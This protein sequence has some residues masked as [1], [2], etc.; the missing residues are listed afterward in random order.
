[1]FIVILCLL[2]IYTIL[3]IIILLLLPFFKNNKPH[4]R[5][6]TTSLLHVTPVYPWYTVTH[7]LE[8]LIDLFSPSVT[9]CSFFCRFRFDFTPYCHL[10]CQWF[11]MFLWP[12]PGMKSLWRLSLAH[13]WPIK[14]ESDI[15][16]TYFACF[17]LTTA[18]MSDWCNVHI[19]LS[20]KPSVL[21]A[22]DG[23]FPLLSLFRFTFHMCAVI[24]ELAWVVRDWAK[25]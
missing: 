24:T 25:W 18:V 22:V 4:Y 23:A 2:L 6:F 15:F 19:G 5:D 14:E 8:S 13:I 3:S 17:N 12:W 1:M 20:V 21:L 9:F 11:I 16:Y 7:D 10:C